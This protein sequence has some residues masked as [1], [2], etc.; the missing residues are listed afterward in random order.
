MFCYVC[1]HLRLGL[2]SLGLSK[3]FQIFPL[4]PNMVNFYV[5]DAEAERVLLWVIS[6]QMETGGESKRGSRLTS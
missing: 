2:K 1:E 4:K 5:K 3:L 6:G